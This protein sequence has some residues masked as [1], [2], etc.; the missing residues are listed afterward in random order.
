MSHRIFPEILGGAPRHEAHHHDGRVYYQ[1]YFKWLDDLFGFTEDDIRR[2]G[3]P[4]LANK[5]KEHQAK[6]GDLVNDNFKR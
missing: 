4:T 3:S 5:R 6:E 1:Q 2:I